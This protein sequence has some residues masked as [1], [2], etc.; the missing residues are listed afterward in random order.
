[1][2]LISLRHS[3]PNIIGSAENNVPRY[4]S[5]SQLTSRRETTYILFFAL[6]CALKILLTD[7]Y[8]S[9]QTNLFYF[10]VAYLVLNAELSYIK[11]PL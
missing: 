1:M 4:E 2:T 8:F 3:A 5:T 7:P 9:H 6:S 10:Y 11:Q